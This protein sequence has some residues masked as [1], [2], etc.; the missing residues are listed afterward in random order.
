MPKMDGEC[1]NSEPG[2]ARDFASLANAENPLDQFF[3]SARPRNIVFRYLLLST[4]F[5]ASV[6]WPLF[7]TSPGQSCTCVEEPEARF[8]GFPGESSDVNLDSSEGSDARAEQFA[9]RL[10][11][12]QLSKLEPVMFSCGPRY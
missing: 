2:A 9:D 11:S 6:G 4:Y 10:R 1:S 3:Q 12:I 5:L 7:F 8:S